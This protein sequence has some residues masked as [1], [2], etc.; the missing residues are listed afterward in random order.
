MAAV[1]PLFFSSFLSFTFEPSPVCGFYFSLS[2]TVFLI[3]FTLALLTKEESVALNLA[4]NWCV[5]HANKCRLGL[6]P[7]SKNLYI[8]H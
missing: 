6:W 4:G 5:A 8:K 7:S 3:I 2:P 1:F